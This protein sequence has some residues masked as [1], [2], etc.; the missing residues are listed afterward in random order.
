MFNNIRKVDLTIASVFASLNFI[1]ILGFSY[2]LLNFEKQPD[3]VKFYKE[4]LEYL[5]YLAQIF[6]VLIALFALTQISFLIDQLQISKADI[7]IRTKR[8]SIILSL[9]V[10]ENFEKNILPKLIKINKF[11]KDRKIPKFNIETNN[12]TQEDDLEKMENW[13]EKWFI[14]IKSIL[15]EVINIINDL[16]SFSAYFLKGLADEE[17]A[18]SLVSAK[19]CKSIED[20]F[21]FIKYSKVK[22]K[23]LDFPRKYNN[24][25]D[26]YELWVKKINN[27]EYFQLDPIGT[28]IDEYIK[29]ENKR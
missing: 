16:E 20:L 12:L 15:P 11:M 1:L 19:Y 28:S 26:L 27:L 22:N 9:Q 2:L 29:N 7:E 24:I 21:F 14:S 13:L 25:L 8:E 17:T 10:C 23:N 18:F 3:R 4:V 6:L 5:Y